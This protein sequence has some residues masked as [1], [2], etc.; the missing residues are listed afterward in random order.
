MENQ[1]KPTGN[2]NIM[3]MSQ[4][5]Q[6]W[7][8]M[9]DRQRGIQDGVSLAYNVDVT[10]LTIGMALEAAKW[11]NDFYLAG[12]AEG[13]RYIQESTGKAIEELLDPEEEEETPL[14]Y[15]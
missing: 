13:F 9:L 5:I 8:E 4:S 6:E 15:V 12:L 2:H 7:H 14:D 3:V 1:I 11:N 10:E